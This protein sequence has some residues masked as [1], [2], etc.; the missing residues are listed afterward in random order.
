LSTLV[1]P[2]AVTVILCGIAM[3]IAVATILLSPTM[4]EYRISRA[5][6]TQ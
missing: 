6:V 3:V 4:R 5:L 2:A 1:G